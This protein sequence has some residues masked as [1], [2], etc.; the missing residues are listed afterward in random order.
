MRDGLQRLEAAA[1]GRRPALR[2]ALGSAADRQHLQR[3]SRLVDLAEVTYRQIADAGAAVRDVLHQPGGVQ[4]PDRLADR[5]RAHLQV[6]GQ[7]F[8]GDPAVAQDAF[9]AVDEGDRAMTRGCVHESG[10]VGH[11]PG[12]DGGMQRFERFLGERAMAP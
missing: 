4:S 2:E 11:E 9:V 12:D 8:D 10:I 7:L 5:H 6:L 1:R 3:H